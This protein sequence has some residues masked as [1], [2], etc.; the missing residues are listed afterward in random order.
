MA[1]ARPWARL[2]HGAFTSPPDAGATLVLGCD[3][4]RT[5]RVRCLSIAIGCL[6]S[7]VAENGG[8]IA[9]AAVLRSRESRQ[10][11]RGGEVP[12]R[13]LRHG[14]RGGGKARRPMA[15]DFHRFDGGPLDALLSRVL[16]YR[17]S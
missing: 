6:L 3:R 1:S 11:R 17:F 2:G 10:S 7:L 16:P 9:A 4:E 13:A 14:R 15:P 8:R 12:P 5:Q